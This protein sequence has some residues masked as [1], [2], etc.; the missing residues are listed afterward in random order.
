MAVCTGACSY[1]SYV[2]KLHHTSPIH[3]PPLD[4]RLRIIAFR[5]ADIS[6]PLLVIR[7]YFTASSRHM[8]RMQTLQV[9]APH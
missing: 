1:L 9:S 2:T 3:L 4:K 7:I 6:L 5:S 8:A